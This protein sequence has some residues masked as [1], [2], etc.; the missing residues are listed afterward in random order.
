VVLHEPKEQ[1]LGVD[2]DIV[3]V[4]CW[5]MCGWKSAFGHVHMHLLRDMEVA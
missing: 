4:F 1:M 3:A 5:R 2:K